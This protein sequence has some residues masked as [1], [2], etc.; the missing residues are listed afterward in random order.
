MKGLYRVYYQKTEDDELMHYG[1]LG[2]KWGVR[3]S[4]KGYH[5]TGIRA[6]LAKRSNDKV[7]K[8]FKKW[9]DNSKK[10]DSAIELGKKANAS[11]IAYEKDKTNK[12]LKNE[13]KQANKEYK[14]ALKLN[15]TYRKGVVK[16]EV[17][18]DAARKYLS[19]ARKVKKQMKNDP[20]NKDL[21]KQYNSLMSNH[22]TSRAK[23]RRAVDIAS[24]RSAKKAA[25]KRTM[26][27]TVKAAAGTAAIATGTY[28]VNRYLSNH[29]VTLNGNRVQFSRQNVNDVV[30]LAK[31]AKNLMG[32][33]V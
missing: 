16:Q 22:D 17:G 26:T 9:Q 24:K 4:D 25:M 2:M 19:E 20:A 29:Q 28:A 32:Y 15:T 10:R 3:R 23:E 13:Y 30:D 6:A 8:S 14:K 12:S 1:V 18:R 21:Q 31:K 5:S 27:M 33:F 11:K 7:D